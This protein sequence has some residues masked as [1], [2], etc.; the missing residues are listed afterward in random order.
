MSEI[1]RR[2]SQYQ[3]PLFYFGSQA[4]WAAPL[5]QRCQ[6]N[7]WAHIVDVSSGLRHLS[8]VGR[9]CETWLG[10]L[11]E[12]LPN[13]MPDCIVLVGETPVPTTCQRWLTASPYR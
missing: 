7:E 10:E 12:R 5:V 9:G 13:E 4:D 2:L 8:S 1:I 11:A 3:R 6:E